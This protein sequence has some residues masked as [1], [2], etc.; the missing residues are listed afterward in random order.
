M[1]KKTDEP[2]AASAFAEKQPVRWSTVIERLIA[3]ESVKPSEVPAPDRG[4]MGYDAYKF[5]FSMDLMSKL[6]TR[7]HDAM[8]ST[9]AGTSGI[10]ITMNAVGVM[11]TMRNNGK[12]AHLTA[13]TGGGGVHYYCDGIGGGYHPFSAPA[14]S[15][16]LV[17]VEVANELA[18]T[19]LKWL[20]SAEKDLLRLDGDLLLHMEP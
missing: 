13:S 9:A 1:M 12:W 6:A 3:G 16:D 2:V 18:L 19:I 4:H 7:L 11:L 5:V 20:M 15:R 17:R 8:T 10:A 14:K